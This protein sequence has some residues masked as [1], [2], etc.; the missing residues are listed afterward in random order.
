MNINRM[1]QIALSLVI[2]IF[3]VTISNHMKNSVY[4]LE[5]ELKQI[6]R[7]IETDIET[8]HILNA[9]W[10]KL[11]NPARLRALVKNHIALN[12]VKAEQIINYSALPFGYETDESRK[13]IARRNIAVYAQNNREFKKMAKTQR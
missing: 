12:P 3:T 4:R 2:I 7:N 13:E 8:I 9:E 6:N 1:T 11:N 10:S 5:D